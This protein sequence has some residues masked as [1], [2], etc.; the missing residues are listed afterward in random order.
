MEISSA[1]SCIDIRGGRVAQCFR[2]PRHCAIIHLF[3]IPA[4][5]SV[6]DGKPCASIFRDLTIIFDW[7][8]FLPVSSADETTAHL[9]GWSV[10]VMLKAS[11]AMPAKV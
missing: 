9:D 2:L 3:T 4:I 8:R 1:F 6:N 10:A 5:G 7:N 11:V